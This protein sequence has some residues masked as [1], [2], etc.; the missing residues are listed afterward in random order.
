M[1]G[2]VLVPSG[3]T[4]SSK[5]HLEVAVPIA[6]VRLDRPEKL[7]VLDLDGW[8]ALASA[9]R[10]LDARD[11]VVVY[12]NPSFQNLLGLMN[13]QKPPLDDPLVRQSS[14]PFDGSV[15]E[16]QSWPF[17]SVRLVGVLLVGP[18]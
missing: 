11:D 15:A 5:V 1:E 18:G 10:E 13:T 14:R 16:N 4:M 2:E 6:T 17:H 9:F 12:S 7:N 8:L 3:V